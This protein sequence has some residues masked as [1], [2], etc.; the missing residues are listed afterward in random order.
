MWHEHW[1]SVF[2]VLH[3][4]GYHLYLRCPT[5]FEFQ[6]CLYVQVYLVNIL[7]HTFN[8][9]SCISMEFH[10]E[11]YNVQWCGNVKPNWGCCFFMFFSCFLVRNIDTKTVNTAPQYTFPVWKCMIRCQ[12]HI[13]NMICD[14]LWSR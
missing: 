12:M 14:S 6:Y 3:R 5:C 8:R 10:H 1:Y 11:K 13:R 7:V 9:F 2:R 4:S